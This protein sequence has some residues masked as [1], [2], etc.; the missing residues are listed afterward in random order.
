MSLL[1]LF[2]GDKGIF[3]K[4]TAEV[5]PPWVQLIN[6]CRQQRK[7]AVHRGSPFMLTPNGMLAHQK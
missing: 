7:K 3:M 1:A 4:I 5:N 2:L 6:S